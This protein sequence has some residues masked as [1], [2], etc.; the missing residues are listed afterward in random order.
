MAQTIHSPNTPY[1]SMALLFELVVAPV[2]L[3]VLEAAIELD[4]AHILADTSNVDEIAEKAGIRTDATS[5][6]H[7]LD[8]MVA[9]GLA[10][11][12]NK[13]YSNTELGKHFLD[14]ASPVFMGDF[15]K[16]LKDMEHKNL[17]RIVEIIKNGPPGV[18]QT[19]DLQ[20]E[21]K[22]ERHVAHLAAYQRA[23]M[24]AIC[25]DLVEELPEFKGIKKILDLGGGPGLIGVE[26]LRRLP[27]AK[28]V[29]LD[30][31]A[32]IRQAKQDVNKEGMADRISFIAGDYNK[33]DLGSGYDLIWAGY[34]LYYAKDRVPFFKRV[35]ETL[36]SK[37]VFVCLHEG[38]THEQ[39]EPENIV[40]MRL[41][42]A[43]EGQS[44]SFNKGEIA[45]CLKQ[46]GFA[47]VDSRMLDL[48]AGQ[49]ELVVGR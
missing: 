21:S 35:K 36:T 34:N 18:P 48:P 32:V 19:E 17:S 38:L 2:K 44:F 46:A 33:I 39:T 30:L 15:V 25:A 49:A 40:L 22:W 10:N 1:P 4:I 45:S 37:G 7:F 20:N 23:G 28:G 11:K 41:S 8:A 14:K 13:T 27:E 12:E 5:L 6:I 16:H 3:A 43:L 47:Q 9:L 26:I 31:P 29:L 42:H 24:G